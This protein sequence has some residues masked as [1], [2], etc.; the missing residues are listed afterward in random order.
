MQRRDFF[1][2]T[3]VGLVGSPLLVAAQGSNGFANDS[4]TQKAKFGFVGVGSRGSY[5]LR[6]VAGFPDVEIVAV[7][8]LLKEKADNAAKICTNAG[9]PAPNVYA[10]SETAWKTLLERE[11]LD[12]VIIATPWDS[13]AAISVSALKKGIYV[14][15]EVPIAMKLDECWELVET[16]EQTK[17]P[18]MML[19]NWSFRQDNL[20]ILNMIRLGLFGE[21]MH[22]HCA[23]SHHLAAYLYNPADGGRTWRSDYVEKTNANY[24]PTHALGP[25]LSW[26]D[27][28]VGDRFKEIY[29]VATA[30]RGINDYMRQ[31]FG[32]DHPR[33]KT[34]LSQ[35]DVITSILKTEN[36]KTV[37]VNLDTNLPRPYANRWMVEGTRGAYDEEK[38]SIYLADASP[39][40]DA[41]EPWQPYQDKYN[42]RFW[43]EEH[44][45]AH[46]GTDALTMRT[47]ADSVVQKTDTPLDVYDSVTMSAVVELS[48]LS[49]AQNRPIEF[50]DFTKGEWKNRKPYFAMDRK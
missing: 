45:G 38:G 41:W 47:F 15:C 9:R 34:K 1:K 33:A 32:E 25:I 14:G 48:A 44:Q 35:G 27:I 31:K 21:I 8:D 40:K 2:T 7:C 16:S 26:F 22:G 4:E 6:T 10:E 5:L 42:H 18:C 49:I 29:S 36:G 46:G 20:A 3:A 11:K 12:A 19:E 43:K 30:A 39:N 50:P 24:Y 17:I 37:V 28:N 13:H 23:Y